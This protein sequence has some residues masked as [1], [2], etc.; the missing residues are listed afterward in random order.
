MLCALL[1]L[2]SR[3]VVPGA[4]EGVVRLEGKP[5]LPAS[6]PVTRDQEACGQEKPDE[7]LVVSPEGNLQYAVVS[8]RGAP[9]E[10]PPE[11]AAEVALDQRGCRYHPH[12]LAARQ[13]SRLV[14]VNSD[15]VLHNA[16]ATRGT[17]TVFNYAFP[18]TGARRNAQLGEAGVLKLSCEAGH[19]WM[20]GFI[21]V[22]P[23]R[24]F[25]VTD[26][27]GHFRLEGVPAGEHELEIWHEPRGGKGEPVVRTVKVKVKEGATA[28]ATVALEL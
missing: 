11:T 3:L 9:A 13:G 25:A 19:S 10:P 26:Q 4:I 23:H 15:T 2:G 5:P 8:L 18:M 14:V 21:A 24:F 20:S 6:I 16:H 22:F 12:V 27:R 1:L 17:Q 28:R 7:S